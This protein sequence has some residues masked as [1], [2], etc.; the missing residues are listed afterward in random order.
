[1]K[2]TFFFHL[3][4]HINLIE[5]HTE[6]PAVAVVGSHQ[7]WLLEHKKNVAQVELKALLHMEFIR[8]SHSDWCRLV[9]FWVDF[10]KV[11]AVSKFDAYS[12]SQ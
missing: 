10:R 1:M 3:P 8:E 7:Y 11:N 12:A 9:Q 4:S 2:E 5:H 6:T